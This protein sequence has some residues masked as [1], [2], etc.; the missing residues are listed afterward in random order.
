M[1]WLA[2]LALAVASLSACGPAAS[3]ASAPDLAPARA[4]VPATPDGRAGIAA[5]EFLGFYFVNTRSRPAFCRANGVDI[6]AFVSQFERVHAPEWDKAQS[7]LRARG[8]DVENVW[9]ELE[10]TLR[11]VVARGLGEGAGAARADPVGTCH[12]IAQTP[13]VALASLTYAKVNPTLDQIL[14]DA[15]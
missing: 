4:P 5:G 7:L 9:L 14:L 12:L 13:D 11:S 1:R 8:L 2:P 15:K 6:G 10:P 3:P